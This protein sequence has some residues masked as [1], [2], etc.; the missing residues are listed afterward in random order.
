VLVA[1]VHELADAEEIERRYGAIN[2]FE[3]AQVDNG[4]VV[5]K[6]F[7]HLSADEQAERLRARLDE[8]DKHWKFMPGD[9]D[10]RERW[11]DYRSAYTTALERC[12]TAAAPWY[13]V[14]SD[15]KWYR[16]WAVGQLLLEALRGMQLEWPEADYDVEEQKARLG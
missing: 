2:A 10:E 9:I 3:K 4:T 11:D 12:R 8:P 5:L 16:N 7:L 15:T 14:P 13:V 1:R 6:C